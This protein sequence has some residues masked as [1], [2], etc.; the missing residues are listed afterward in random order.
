[1]LMALPDK[2]CP[3]QR[4]MNAMFLSVEAE[5]ISIARHLLCCMDRMEVISCHGTGNKQI[6]DLRFM[7]TQQVINI[8][9]M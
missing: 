6:L 9:S 5:Y 2:A 1:M 4:K 7:R 3:Q 8:F